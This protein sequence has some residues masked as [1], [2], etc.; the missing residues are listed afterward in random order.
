MIVSDCKITIG[1]WDSAGSSVRFDQRPQ[2]SLSRLWTGACFRSDLK[3][4]DV[5]PVLELWSLASWRSC[6]L[7]VAS[8]RAPQ[9]C[10]RTYVH[11]VK[12]KESWSSL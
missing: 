2:L 11:R 7:S 3:L 5:G 6:I 9:L 1:L 4:G 12:L 8:F 10:I